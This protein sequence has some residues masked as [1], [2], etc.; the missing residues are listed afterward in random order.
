MPILSF[1]TSKIKPSGPALDISDEI[2]RVCVHTSLG[3]AGA[4][5][6]LSAIAHY[7]MGVTPAV[8][9]IEFSQFVVEVLL[10]L[11]AICSRKFKLV[12]PIQLAVAF[13]GMSAVLL[14]GGDKFLTNSFWIAVIAPIYIAVGLRRTGLVFFLSS[15]G[16]LLAYFEIHNPKEGSMGAIFGLDAFLFTI[17][18]LVFVMVL[19]RWQDKLYVQ[20]E[21]DRQKIESLERA[22]SKYL[23]EVNHELRN[24]IAVIASS[25]DLLDKYQGRDDLFTQQVKPDQM[26]ISIEQLMKNIKATSNHVLSVLN[27]V[28]ELDRLEVVHIEV[29]NTAF[30]LR[31]LMGDVSDIY[32]VQ[33]NNVGSSIEVNLDRDVA[34]AWVGQEAKVRQILLNLLSNALNHAPGSR[35]EI[36]AS[37]RSDRLVFVVAD[38][39]PGMSERAIK[40]LYEPYAASLG[41]KGTSGL[42]LRICKM[43]VEQH[44][45]GTIN[46]ES[47][48]GLGTTFT[49]SLPLKKKFESTEGKLN[50]EGPLLNSSEGK[51]LHDAEEIQR[52]LVGKSLLLVE[53]DPDNREILMMLLEDA[54]MRVVSCSNAQQAKKVV[55]ESESFDIAIL[56]HNLGEFSETNG[57]ELTPYLLAK[58]VK[59]VV[60]YSGNPSHDLETRWQAAGV[61]SIMRKPL[62]LQRLLL[63]LSRTVTG[64]KWSWRSDTQS[65]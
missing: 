50:Q 2:V 41:A 54:G 51:H 42:G 9:I 5:S 3:A 27:D 47:T 48:Q 19:K 31:K 6:L 36:G 52:N 45:G 23:I 21:L 53:D 28:L 61:F 17:A 59:K 14:L 32:A 57:I 44:L 30:S 22:K 37:E 63:S 26:K 40:H 8:P 24:P 33:A 35:I 18:M 10:W 46:V 43:L 7:Q 12:L 25:I 20:V 34:D 62:S 11:Y 39:G 16:L 1:L 60:G 58:G 64:Q 13:F 49:V 55:D 38:S 15:L 29:S 65:S 56:D 4:T